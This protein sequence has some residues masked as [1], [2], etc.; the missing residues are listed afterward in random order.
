M[1]E[2]R[3]KC[4]LGTT[5][6]ELT[7]TPVHETT[8]TPGATR[9]TTKRTVSTTTKRQQQ[10]QEKQR[11]QQQHKHQRPDINIQMEEVTPL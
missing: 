6:W 1:G 2:R 5:M 10:Q 11:K 7:Q 4:L 9:R 3:S 8:T